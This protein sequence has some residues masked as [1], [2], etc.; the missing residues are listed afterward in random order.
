MIFDIYYKIKNIDYII[1]VIL[2]RKE[3]LKE[4]F[5]Y[6]IYLVFYYIYMYLLVLFIDELFIKK[7]D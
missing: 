7:C 4:L 2:E 5:L 6:L 3:K 1:E